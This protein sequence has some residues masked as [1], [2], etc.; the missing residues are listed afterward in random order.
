MGAYEVCTYNTHNGVRAILRRV[1]VSYPPMPVT[2]P[3]QKFEG[4]LFYPDKK[5]RRGHDRVEYTGRRIMTLPVAVSL[6][7]P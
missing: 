2:A 1:N 4:G 3:F 6:H 5:T 7:A